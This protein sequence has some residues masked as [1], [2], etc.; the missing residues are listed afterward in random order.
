MTLHI[1]SFIHMSIELFQEQDLDDWT[2]REQ[3]NITVAFAI[4]THV[5]C[6]VETKI[7]ECA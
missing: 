3:T 5:S 7:K 6:Y 4:A 2:E 1:S